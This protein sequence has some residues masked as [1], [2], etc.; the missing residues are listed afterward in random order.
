MINNEPVWRLIQGDGPLV[1]AAVHDGHNVRDEVKAQLAL[2]DEQRL[3]EEDPYTA[4]WTAVAPTRVIGTHSRF[5]VDLNR[6]REKAVYVKP[7]D[8]WGLAVWKETPSPGLLSRSLEEYDAFYAAVRELFGRL[9]DRHDRFVV[10]DLH[11]YN[12]RR[13]GPQAPAADAEANP[14]VNIGT[15]TMDRDFWAPI[16]DRFIAD[17]RGFDFLGRALDVRENIKFRGGGFG[18]WVHETYP[19]AGCAIAIEFKKFFMDECTGELDTRQH[20]AIT[21]ALKA[22]V[23]GLLQELGKMNTGKGI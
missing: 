11:T 21:A 16:I 5:E 17:L 13:A 20:E 22:T 18:K 6:P 14:E 1:A 4:D 23:P 12:H 9:A 2:T 3:R 10:F 15:G 8:A 19:R 7:E